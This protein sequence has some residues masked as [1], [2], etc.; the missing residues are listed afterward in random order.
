MKIQY[1]AK[2]TQIIFCV[3]YTETCRVKFSEWDGSVNG[4]V[5]PKT[6]ILK[7][8]DD[9]FHFY[10]FTIRKRSLCRCIS[11]EVSPLNQ[12]LKAQIFHFNCIFTTVSIS[13]F[14]EIRNGA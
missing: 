3:R 11:M 2:I 14:H 13:L 7:G 4:A 6:M 12:K 8:V 1:F 5:W 10:S 9:F